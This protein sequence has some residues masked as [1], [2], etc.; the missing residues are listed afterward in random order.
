MLNDL[1]HVSQR[2][3]K[4]YDLISAMLPV[5]LQRFFQMADQRTKKLKKLPSTKIGKSNAIRVL[6]V[7]DAAVIRDTISRLLQLNGYEVA[8]AR[9]GQE[10]VEM[11]LRWQPDVVLMDLRMPVMDGYDAIDRIKS[12]PRT[13]HIPVFVIS[14]WSSKTERAKAK[15]VGADNFFVKPPNLNHLVSAIEDAVATSS[16]R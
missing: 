15:V 11:T 2:G 10:G 8:Y 4:L 3:Q 6:Y 5:W 12:D 9:N 13:C 7:E 1:K 16:R 14:A